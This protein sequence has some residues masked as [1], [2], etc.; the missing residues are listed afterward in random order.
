[1]KCR[2]PTLNL[3]PDF[4]KKLT[5]DATE[6]FKNSPEY[7]PPTARKRRG[8]LETVE[9]SD[10]DSIR[11]RSAQVFETYPR[12]IIEDSIYTIYLSFCLSVCLSVFLSLCLSV[13]PPV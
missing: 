2:M 11:R 13:C 5:Q 8:L 7:L 1:M 3:T 4:I 9:A 12:A 10:A 6:E